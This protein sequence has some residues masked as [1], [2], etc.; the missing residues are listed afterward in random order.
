MVSEAKRRIVVDP[1]ICPMVV[2]AVHN[3]PVGTR[4]AGAVS[5]SP[6]DTCGFVSVRCLLLFVSVQDGLRSVDWGIQ[7]AA[8]PDGPFRFCEP[9]PLLAG[10]TDSN[11]GVSWLDVVLG[12]RVG[13]ER[14]IRV[15]VTT[16]GP[17]VGTF[18]VLM[19]L[20]ATPPT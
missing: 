4:S 16:E 14:F 19:E 2:R 17:G 11:E 9:L 8:T 6:V 12:E 20:H 18:G 15:R 13:I 10:A 3:V 1:T 5:G 7:H